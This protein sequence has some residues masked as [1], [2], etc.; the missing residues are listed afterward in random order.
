[1]HGGRITSEERSAI[2]AYKSVSASAVGLVEGFTSSLLTQ[3][4]K[5][6]DDNVRSEPAQDQRCR[7][8]GPVKGRGS[9]EVR[10]NSS[11][12]FSK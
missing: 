3:K 7:F 6:E 8:K 9:Y 10:G 12:T 11:N 4:E 5:K 2:G 1:M